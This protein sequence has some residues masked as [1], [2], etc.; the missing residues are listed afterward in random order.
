MTSGGGRETLIYGVL[1]PSELARNCP[2]SKADTIVCLNS[3][4]S[5]PVPRG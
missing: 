2:C 5:A 4:T 3:L 1:L